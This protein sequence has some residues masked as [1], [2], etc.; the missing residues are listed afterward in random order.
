DGGDSCANVETGIKRVSP[1]KKFNDTRLFTKKG[2][3]A[4]IA[5]N[6][7]LNVVKRKRV[8]VIVVHKFTSI[9]PQPKNKKGVL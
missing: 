3:K 4:C 7:C 8:G 2:T 5:E 9:K 1:S 6:V